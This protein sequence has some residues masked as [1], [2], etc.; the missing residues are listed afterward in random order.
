MNAPL[1]SDSVVMVLNTGVRG[2][3]QVMLSWKNALAG[4]EPKNAI[5][6]E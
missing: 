6:E 4:I 5:A 1:L 2:D 3:A